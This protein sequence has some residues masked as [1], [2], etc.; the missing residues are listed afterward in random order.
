MTIT[1]VK[2][3]PRVA[4]NDIMSYDIGG[5]D[6]ASHTW[7]YLLSPRALLDDSFTSL[8]LKPRSEWGNTTASE[9]SDRASLT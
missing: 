8:A 2:N 5:N 7:V 4:H 3:G 6:V 1:T 9:V